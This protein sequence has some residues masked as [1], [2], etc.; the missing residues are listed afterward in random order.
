MK[1]GQPASPI[2]GW[3][4]AQEPT[5]NPQFPITIPCPDIHYKAIYIFE[6]I[7]RQHSTDLWNENHKLS[8]NTNFSASEIHFAWNRNSDFLLK[9][10]S[11]TKDYGACFPKAN[12]LPDFFIVLSMR[13]CEWI[14]NENTGCWNVERRCVLSESPFETLLLVNEKKLCTETSLVREKYYKSATWT[15]MIH[16]WKSH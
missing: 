16:S 14:R 12:V 13:Y 8:S 2:T 7:C 9:I 6:M 3:W 1:L 15:V 5:H 10:T 4:Q 11:G